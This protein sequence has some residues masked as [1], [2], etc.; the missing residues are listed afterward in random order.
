MDC[1]DDDEDAKKRWATCLPWRRD[2]LLDLFLLLAFCFFFLP[3][4]PFLPL[5]DFFPLVAEGEV[6]VSA[7]DS[8][9]FVPAVPVRFVRFGRFGRLAVRVSF[10]PSAGEATRFFLCRGDRRTTA[11]ARQEA[12]RKGRADRAR[13]ATHTYQK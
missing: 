12:V 4:L 10:S 8:L 9:L 2:R 3:F 11:M 5:P 7:A 1:A 13:P 6:G